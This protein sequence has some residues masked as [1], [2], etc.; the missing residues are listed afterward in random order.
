MG[1]SDALR[2]PLLLKLARK[3]KLR[4]P[5]A[6]V[7]HLQQLHAIRVQLAL[8]AGRLRS[9]ILEIVRRDLGRKKALLAPTRSSDRVI[10]QIASALPK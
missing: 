7:G 6:Q 1:D 4:A 10:G 9:L 3:G 5:G 2:L 8:R